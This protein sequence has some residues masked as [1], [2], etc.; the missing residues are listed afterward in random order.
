VPIVITG[1]GGSGA[2]ASPTRGRILPSGDRSEWRHEVLVWNQV[3]SSASWSGLTTTDA[4]RK[5]YPL[6]SPYAIP[7][8]AA[9]T[10]DGVAVTTGW[11]LE[12]EALVFES[13]QAEGAAIG[14]SCW[15]TEAAGDPLSAVTVRYGVWCPTGAP[16]TLEVT[17]PGMS[18]SLSWVRVPVRDVPS[19]CVPGFLA[20]AEGGLVP[21]A[22]TPA[23]DTAGTRAYD[24][25]GVSPFV[26]AS[27]Y[28]TLT[29]GAGRAFCFVPE[30]PG[31]LRAT[32]G[33]LVLPD[34]SSGGA[35]SGAGPQGGWTWQHRGRT[36]LVEIGAGTGLD[37]A[38]ALADSA[39]SGDTVAS[40][41]PA[42]FW[43]LSGI[44]VRRLI[45]GAD[46]I[47]LSGLTIDDGDGRYWVGANLAVGDGGVGRGDWEAGD[48]A[49]KLFPRKWDS[50]N[51]GDGAYVYAV[52]P[53]R[54]FPLPT[55]PV[56]QYLRE[57][58]SGRIVRT[59]RL[60]DGRY[61]VDP[62]TGRLTVTDADQPMTSWPGPGWA[63]HLPGGTYN[64]VAA[65]IRTTWYLEYLPGGHTEVP[66]LET[67]YDEGCVSGPLWS[68]SVP[69][70][71]AVRLTHEIDDL[72][73]RGREPQYNALT[74]GVSGYWDRT[75]PARNAGER[76]FDVLVLATG[77]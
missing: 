16:E 6:P 60:V 69:R 11:T 2:A 12:P 77:G 50:T 49:G 22:P 59:R 19:G 5:R 71:H 27:D 25:G 21:F 3:P 26:L 45:A 10:V 68:V 13:G 37:P 38:A 64:Y 54:F 70:G 76:E 65:R 9:V 4:E 66:T 42:A 1:T 29:G 40:L 32:L 20:G 7:W 53:F 23:T 63:N 18:T 61:S 24:A 43:N 35:L 46:S 75:E 67:G 58:F 47:S 31:R 51:E 15:R 48:A 17:V 36:S 39:Y 55:A 74:G 8:G 44:A 28:A 72:I 34:G 14:L 73:W 62:V 30:I 52:T 57:F 41:L 56:M 33:D